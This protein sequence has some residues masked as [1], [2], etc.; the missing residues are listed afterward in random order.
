M[1]MDVQPADILQD[2]PLP[3][4][5]AFY[6]KNHYMGG[7]TTQLLKQIESLTESMESALKK[8]SQ[9]AKKRR[10]SSVFRS[11]N[12]SLEEIK[13]HSEDD[14][15]KK[16][17]MDLTSLHRERAMNEGHYCQ[18]RRKSRSIKHDKR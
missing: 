6:F 3:M 18:R 2:I 15:R 8:V 11:Y 12:P 5:E 7:D 17:E 16:Q 14:G 9:D 1:I 13:E 10:R 4:A